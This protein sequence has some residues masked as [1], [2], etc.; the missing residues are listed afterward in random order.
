MAV[1]LLDNVIATGS[2]MFTSQTAAGPGKVSY[3]AAVEGGDPM[4][5]PVAG[6]VMQQGIPFGHGSRKVIRG[7]TEAQVKDQ[8]TGKLRPNIIKGPSGREYVELAVDEKDMIEKQKWEGEVSALR[9]REAQGAAP[10]KRGEED[11]LIKSRVTE[12]FDTIKKID[13]DE[14]DNIADRQL[15]NALA[16][17]P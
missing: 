8:K 6:Q 17:A 2:D 11:E 16:D 12:C 3:W 15:K 1:E 9:V 10:V 4:G 14:I 5:N 13:D 7:I